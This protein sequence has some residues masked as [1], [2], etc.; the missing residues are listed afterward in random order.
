M[1]T[2][3]E[4]IAK[5]RADMP[6]IYRG[7]YDKAMSGKSKSSALH[8]QCLECMGWA[9]EEVRLC[10]SPECPLFPYRP[11]SGSKQAC[12]RHDSGAGSTILKKVSDCTDGGSL[13]G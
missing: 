12:E 7:I 5:Y 8:T 13:C 4:R 3:Q 6:K 2:P 1:K 11:Y 9:R 10:C